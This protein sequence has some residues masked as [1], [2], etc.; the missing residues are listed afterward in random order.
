M[1][2]YM[3]GG[4]SARSTRRPLT[5]FGK[6]RSGR[7]PRMRTNIPPDKSG[8]D[9]TPPRPTTI[10]TLARNSAGIP[11][12]RSTEAIVMRIAREH[13]HR[14]QA[15][16]VAHMIAHTLG[17]EPDA[18]LRAHTAERLVRLVRQAANSKAAAMPGITKGV[19]SAL[20]VD[21]DRIVPMIKHGLMR[22]AQ[23]EQHPTW[24]GA[25]A[26]FASQEDKLSFLA[27]I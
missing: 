15:A 24:Q 8:M 1:N 21:E 27:Q 10:S 4:P 13:S 3:A 22:C 26:R 9:R 25:L 12:G 16:L 18:T 2:Q 20:G 19:A 11:T 17:R 6:R 5:P 23:I 7:A 14:P